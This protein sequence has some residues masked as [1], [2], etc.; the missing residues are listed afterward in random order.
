MALRV[1]GSKDARGVYHI[2]TFAT[3]H[4]AGSPAGLSSL[5]I[6]FVSNKKLSM[7]I[8]MI[9]N[10]YMGYARVSTSEQSLAVQLDALQHHRCTKIFQEVCTK[11]LYVPGHCPAHILSYR[12]LAAHRIRHKERVEV[13]S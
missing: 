7:P 5:F 8:E 4:I 10:H 1:V 9:C 12:D 2:N 3:P 11:Y 6:I 13:S